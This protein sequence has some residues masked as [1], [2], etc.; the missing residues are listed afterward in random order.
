MAPGCSQPLGDGVKQFLSTPSFSSGNRCTFLTA[1]VN[2][3]LSLSQWY[4]I[5][6]WLVHEWI[7]GQV[8]LILVIPYIIYNENWWERSFLS[9]IMNTYGV[10]P[11]SL[12]YENVKP[13][14]QIWRMGEQKLYGIWISGSHFGK[15]ISPSILHDYIN[16]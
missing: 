14:I 1:K 6:Q 10:N 13:H 3:W 16:Q 15:A 2:L 11:N 9:L 8:N 7:Y 4:L 5:Y 12:L